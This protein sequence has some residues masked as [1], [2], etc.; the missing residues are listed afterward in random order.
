MTLAAVFLTSLLAST[1][2]QYRF[3]EDVPPET[4]YSVVLKLVPDDGGWVRFCTLHSVRERSAEGPAVAVTPGDAY[5]A[6]ACR[7]LSSKKWK[8]DRDGAGEVKATFYFCRYL[9]SSPD[10]AYCERRFGD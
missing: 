2:A 5:V 8:I 4:G 1:A 3:A 7:K 6:D 9:E 10:R